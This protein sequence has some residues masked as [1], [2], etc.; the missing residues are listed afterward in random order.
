MLHLM[1]SAKA[2]RRMGDQQRAVAARLVELRH[3]LGYRTQESFADAAGLKRTQ[4][5]QA[6]GPPGTMGKT[7][8]WHEAVGRAAGVSSE[9]AARYLSGEITLPQVMAART[10]GENLLPKREL[11]R[12]SAIAEGIADRTITLWF[13]RHAAATGLLSISIEDALRDMKAMMRVG[14]EPEPNTAPIDQ[15]EAELAARRA[16]R[17]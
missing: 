4:I 2:P 13:E 8:L 12:Q 10:A 1:G 6:E 7:R 3:A 16:R 14:P 15:A 11:I 5:V 17:R 9:V